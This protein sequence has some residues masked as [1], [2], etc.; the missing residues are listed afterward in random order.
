[1]PKKPGSKK[2]TSP[3]VAKLASEILRDGRYSSKSKS[4]AAAALAQAKGK[5]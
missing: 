4:V 1:M 3:R 2:I 5:K